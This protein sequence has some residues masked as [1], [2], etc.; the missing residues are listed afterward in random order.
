VGSGRA[1]GTSRAT[2]ARVSPA[3][4]TCRLTARVSPGSSEALLL[5]SRC[6]PGAAVQAGGHNDRATIQVLHSTTHS[7]TRAIIS[8]YDTSRPWMAHDE[9]TW[10]EQDCRTP[11]RHPRTRPP[12]P[13]PAP[14]RSR[15]PDL[16]SVPWIDMVVKARRRT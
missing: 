1:G 13:D 3:S 5:R 7:S 2:H 6:P 9:G 4:G 11:R 15:R 8:Y 10:A 12:R 14:V 16:S